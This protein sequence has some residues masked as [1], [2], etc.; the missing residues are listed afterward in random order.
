MIGPKPSQ[1]GERCA[2]IH[3]K[4]DKKETYWDGNA[5]PEYAKGKRKSA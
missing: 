3:T 5:W 4:V 1:G 2:R